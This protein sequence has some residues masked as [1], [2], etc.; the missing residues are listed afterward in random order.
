MKHADKGPRHGR[1]CD[2][3]R[4]KSRNGDRDADARGARRRHAALAACLAAAL[5][6]AAAAQARDGATPDAASADRARTLVAFD[7]APQPLAAALSD[8]A[9]QAGV[10][11]LFAYGDVA[12]TRANGVHGRFTREEALERLTAGLGL[13]ARLTSAGLVVDA[14]S[15]LDPDRS[16]GDGAARTDGAHTQT[17]PPSGAR[18]GA[19]RAEAQSPNA[20]SASAT[21]G[22]AAPSMD[23][24]VVTGTRIRGA[25]PTGSHVVTIDRDA[26]EATGRTSIQDVLQTLPQAF[27][28]SQ[29][30]LTQL[31][32]TAG[33]RNIAFSASVDLR[34]LGA[35]ATL[36]LVNGRRLAPA[37][38]GNFVDISAVPLAAVD[39]VEVLADGA[40]A[41]YGSDAVGGVVNIILRRDFNGAETTVR[42]GAATAGALEE[43]GLSHVFGATRG[44]SAFLAGYEYR[45]RDA[46]AASDRAFAADTDLRRFG[47]SNFSRTNA[48]PGNIIRV[49]T[50]VTA[51][52]IPAGQNGITLRQSDLIAGQLNFQNG[53]EGAS[54]LPAQESHGLFM[55]ARLPLGDR[56]E[57][58][59]DALGSRRK[60]N[61]SDNQLA[62]TLVVP[63]TNAYRQLNGLFPGTQPIT[64]AYFLG[65]DLGPLRYATTSDTHAITGGLEIDIARAWRL[66]ATATF[67]GHSDA[68]RF[69]NAFDST[70]IAGALAS[71]DPA[72]AFNP[73]GDGAHTPAAVLRNLTLTQATDSDSDIRA[74]AIK[75]DGPLFALPA[76]VV[77]AAVGAERRE[78]A[79]AITRVERRAS[80]LL[81]PAALQAPGERAVSAVFGELYLPLLSAEAGLPLVESLAASLS[82]R[83][84]SSDDF[85]DATTPKAGVRLDA[86]GGLSLRGAW[87]KSFKAPQFVQLLGG[88][89]GTISSA[90][91]SIDPFATNGSTGTL[92]ITGANPNLRPETAET[93]TL[94]FDLSPPALK[95]LTLSATYFDIDFANRISTPGS[96]LD[97]LRNSAAYAGFLI[98]DPTPEQI[99]AYLAI[100][101]RTAG[102]IPPDG[103][104]AIWD[105][106]LTNLAS[107]RVRG[108]DLSGAWRVE[109]SA[110]A[111]TLAASASKLMEFRRQS[112]P[113]VPAINPLDTI[114]NPVDWR[115]RASLAWSGDHWRLSGALNYTDDY[116][117]TLSTPARRIDAWRTWDVQIAR[118]W[119]ADADNGQKPGVEATLNV[120]NITD[121]DPPFANNPVGMAFDTL[122]ASPLG[123]F[124]SFEIRRRW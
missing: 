80:G 35:D 88:T 28:G 70:A 100:P 82:V 26:I 68:V 46:L 101:S 1:A 48:N 103:I 27:S 37:G 112:N 22:A 9:R 111:I 38:F 64:V 94:G 33:G 99:A 92:Q 118:T 110:G 72:T 5:P 45:A 4:Q 77:R 95:G 106:R 15:A 24:V 30:E 85:G 7:I 25:P 23:E 19:P 17:S 39:R 20:G 51:F 58:F 84:E 63:A 115:G 83:H 61:A 117:D 31:N 56:I 105:E 21:M 8:F 76:G 81:V 6:A 98:R 18:A 36:T 53:N 67:G 114:L 75:A 66:E 41:T 42:Y 104:E 87:G 96:I 97:A 109:T 59:A 12:Q 73:F 29:N 108:V 52:A 91:V 49:G 57:L 14:P 44:R 107:L 43:K 79:F 124:V 116:L 32:S 74:Y 13:S 93:W 102:T 60:A 3:R 78:E 54:L 65:D 71:S 119:R 62:T 11:A 55:S 40:S 69:S 2:A 120:R 89:G 90:P 50:T 86:A 121:A 10:P 47:G 16:G 34:G 122:N 113:V 123:R